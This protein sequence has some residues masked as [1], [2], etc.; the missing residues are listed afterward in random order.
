MH[1]P[2]AV[3]ELE[4]L[5]LDQRG[6]HRALCVARLL[7]PAREE[8]GL[9]VDEPAVGIGREALH[10]GVDGE[11]DLLREVLVDGDLPPGIIVAVR[12]EVHVDL[13]LDRA[14]ACVILA[15]LGEGVRWRASR[16]HGFVL[17][18]L[19]GWDLVVQ[20]PMGRDG[21]LLLGKVGQHIAI[22][23]VSTIGA[24]RC[25]RHQK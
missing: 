9:H 11:E 14:T 18:E 5:V 13:A 17:V 1:A 15:V 16:L 4:L 19:D 6:G 22:E 23:V 7:P 21:K 12:H 3:G 10:D 20:V 24:N 2:A 25:R 8:S